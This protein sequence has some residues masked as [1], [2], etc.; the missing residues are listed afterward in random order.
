MLNNNSALLQNFYSRLG[1]FK[2]KGLCQNYCGPVPLT[3]GEAERLGIKGAV[4]TPCKGETLSCDFL[5]SLGTCTEYENRPLVCRMFGA[6]DTPLLKCPHGCAP[7]VGRKEGDLMRA[8]YA[9]MVGV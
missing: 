8:K 7:I 9:E 4:M 3:S 5:S 1:S 2:C 6:V